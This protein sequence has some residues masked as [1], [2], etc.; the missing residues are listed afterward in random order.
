MLRGEVSVNGSKLSAGDG[1]SLTEEKNLRI[2][3]SADS[4]IMIFDLA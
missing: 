3:S 4:E 1:I 2:S